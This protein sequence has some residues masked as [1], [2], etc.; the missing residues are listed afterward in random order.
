MQEIFFYGL[1]MDR[2]LLTQKGLS[3]SQPRNGYIAG[4]GLRIGNRA[5]LVHAEAEKAYGVVM[6]LSDEEAT[7]L[8]AEA[9]VADYVP[10]SVVVTLDSGESL[11]ATCY[12][13]PEHLRAGSN[14]AYA[15]ALV[16]VAIKCGLPEGYI[17]VIKQFGA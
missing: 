6:R 8:Y 12:N 17:D 4:L 13:L 14:A 2:G 5:T 1:F 15:K 9:S 11:E 3:P 10:E 16:E 7:E